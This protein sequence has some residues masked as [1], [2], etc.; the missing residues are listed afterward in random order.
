VN[1]FL[2]TN[3]GQTFS[4]LLA[5]N[6]PN[7]GSAL[8]VLPNVNSTRARIKVQAANNIFFDLNNADFTVAPGSPTPLIQLT[9]TS[10]IAESCPPPN[11]AVDPYETVTVNWTL[12]NFGNAPTTN[13]V[14][15][16]L[17]TN[18]VYY[19]GAPQNYGAIAAGGS[20]TRPFQFVPA[21]NCG[22]AVTGLVQLADGAVNMGTVSQVFPLGASQVT[23][24]T[25]VFANASSISIRDTNSA[26][27]YPSTISVSGISNVLK[28]TAGVVGLSHTWPDD[29]G[30]LLVAPNGQTAVLMDSCGGS[31]DVVGISLTFDDGAA[32]WLPDNTAIS[33]GTYRPTGQ[34]APAGSYPSPAPAYPYGTNM[35]A[36]APS[37]NGTWSLY[38]ADFSTSDT[39]SISGGWK[40]TFITSNVVAMCCSTF[41]Q[42]TMTSTTYSN[43]VVRFAWTALPG[44]HYQVQYRTN[45][46]AG[47]WQNLGAAILG[48]NTLM[49][50]TDSNTNAP[51]RFYRVQVLP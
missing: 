4:F 46:A 27:P 12:S 13:L 35:T 29:I 50:F 47:S 26:L 31:T 42:P 17:A 33:A 22:G 45:L 14:A 21:G 3:S 30:I 40:V 5:T 10:L 41:P 38:V 43:N 8:V 49:S 9:G 25:Q 39:G 11:G 15:T 44:P 2:S 6:V 18:G 19:P 37:P 23:V 51:A 16:L 28:V 36:L 48:T 7:S 24:V 34:F 32:G 1:I 20:V